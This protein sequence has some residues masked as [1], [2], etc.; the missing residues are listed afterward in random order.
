MKLLRRKFLHLAAGAA[1]LPTLPRIARA[2]AYP[3]RPVRIIV[4]FAPAGGTDI[5]ARLIGQRLS[6]RLGQQFVIENRPGAATNIA[7]EAVVNAPPDGYT[8]LAA[9][10]PNASNATVYDKLSFNFIRD[11]APV[12][13]IARDTFVIEVNPSVPVK[14]VPE[15]IAYAKVN[16]GKINMASGGIGSGNH[17]FGELFKRMTGVN[18]VHVPYRGAGPALVDLLGG[19]VQVMFASISSSIE[20][21]RAG[22][23]RALAVTTSTRSPVLPDIPTVAE[24]VPGY[25]ATFWTG[26]GAPRNTPMEIVGKLNEEIN[27]VLAD[28]PMKARLAGLGAAALP[29]SPGD[30]GR[31]ITGET[32]KWGEVVKSAGI[33]A[34]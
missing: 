6:E 7:T 18:L 30:F 29:G 1:A 4:G 16:S 10:L 5:L 28:A 21:V 17:I 22:K 13:G 15:L 20:Y 19:Q 32:E 2:Q 14:T 25:E 33:K 27:A 31:L 34:E 23:L 12:A 24:F 26:I 9:C 3:S 11:I 8:L